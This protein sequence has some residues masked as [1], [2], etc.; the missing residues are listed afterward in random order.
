MTRVELVDPVVFSDRTCR[1]VPQNTFFPPGKRTR[2]IEKAKSY[3]RVC[4]RLVQCAEW[5]QPL[6]ASGALAGCVVAAVYLPGPHKGQAGRDA[7][8]AELAE[9]VAYG[10]MSEADVE[11]AA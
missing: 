3:C 5:A 1:D 6:A 4:P 2:E 10:R 9:I 7:A 11:G 8:V